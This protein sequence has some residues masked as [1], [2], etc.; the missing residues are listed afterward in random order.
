MKDPKNAPRHVAIIMDGNGRW[1]AKRGL[2]KIA[3]HREGVRSIE[4][5]MR[6]AVSSGVKILTLY[7][8]STENWNRPRPEVDALFALMEEYID[9]EADKLKTDNVR[10]SVI[11]RMDGIPRRIKEKI[12]RLISETAE[13]SGL[14]LNLAIN[15]GGRAEI[16]D[17]C[18]AISKDVQAGIIA[19]DDITEDRFQG[20]LYTRGI[21]DPDLMIRTSGEMRL[22]NFLLWQL[23]YAEFYIT[24]VLWP[25]FDG[26]EFV[27]AVDDYRYRDRRYGG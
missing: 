12:S 21:P 18:R 11:G 4:K 17:A 24:P 15:Y 7:T 19:S 26:S 1:A 5:V 23:S 8:F 2:P 20:Y 3:G 10:L 27:K 16:V 22:S 9:S 25:D 13:N 6:A 14:V